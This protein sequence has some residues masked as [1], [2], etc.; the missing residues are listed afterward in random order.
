MIDRVYIAVS[1]TDA[2]GTDMK[3]FF[4]KKDARREIL[5]WLGEDIAYLVEEI[6]GI[7]SSNESE[8]KKNE[9]IV[10]EVKSFVDSIEFYRDKEGSIDS[11]Y[12]ADFAYYINETE[13]N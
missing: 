7:D 13:I 1:E 10:N 2:A 6:K 8:S 5:S 9:R 4:D 3:V 12:G 11:V